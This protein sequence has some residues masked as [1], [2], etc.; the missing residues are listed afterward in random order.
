[1]PGL[2][3]FRA[4]LRRT[5]CVLLG[6]EDDAHAALADLL[7]QLVGADD[8]AGPLRR[9]AA[10][11]SSAV[12]AGGG[13]S[14]KLPASSWAA[15]QRLDLP[16]SAGVAAAGLVEVGGPLA[17]R[18]PSPGRRGRSIR[19]S[20][21]SV[22]G[23]LLGDGRPVMTV[24]RIGGRTP[25]GSGNFLVEPAR[26]ASPAELGV[27]AR[28]GRR[29]SGESAVRRRDAEGLR[30]P[31]STVRPA[32]KRSLTSSALRGSL[33]G[34]PVEGL[35]EGE[36]VVGRRRRRRARRRRGRRRSPAAAVLEPPLAA[37]VVDEDAAHGL[38]GGGEEVAAAVPVLGLLGVRPAGGRPRG[39]GRWPGASGRASPGP[40]SGRP[41]CA[42]RRRPAAGAA[43]RRWGSPCSMAERMRVTSFMSP[44]IPCASPMC[45]RAVA[46]AARRGVR[47]ARESCSARNVRRL[48]FMAEPPPV[49]RTVGY[50]AGE[51][52]PFPAAGGVGEPVAPAA[53]TA[54]SPGV[55]RP[56]LTHSRSSAAVSGAV[57][58]VSTQEIT[59][60][61]T[62]SASFSSP[63][64]STQ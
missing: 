54:A 5:G 12:G 17:R 45:Q 53:G 44:R 47:S 25:H 32:K 20:V 6:H 7:Q 49:P 56:L 52:P 40:A 26:L 23:R 55:T 46:R 48:V 59:S 35:V 19:R 41:A 27:A 42:A 28:R 51:V 63:N 30:R 62:E 22:H 43:R 14:R 29:P 13:G 16:R 8:R 64:Q 39:P 9:S 1:M 10:G 57:R 24:R 36:Q 18:A 11:R 38:G 31:R 61:R 15:Q 34:Q 50:C 58:S 37:G 2:M 33:G 4:T 3:T 21:G 60:L